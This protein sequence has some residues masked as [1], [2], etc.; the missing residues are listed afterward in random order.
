M[1]RAFSMFVFLF[2][3]HPTILIQNASNS[4]PISIVQ[5]FSKWYLWKAILCQK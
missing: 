1:A 4:L 3:S 5:C 2:Q